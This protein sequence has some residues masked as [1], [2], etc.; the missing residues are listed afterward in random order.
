MV[1][2]RQK[3]LLCSSAPLRVQAEV[4]RDEAQLWQDRKMA[5]E[6]RLWASFRG[7]TLAR[8]VEGMMLAEKA[9]RLQASWDGSAFKWQLVWRAFGIDSAALSPGSGCLWSVLIGKKQEVT[10]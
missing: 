7:Q 9:L 5:L 1:F 3:S 6:L 10:P 8:T 2:L 4:G